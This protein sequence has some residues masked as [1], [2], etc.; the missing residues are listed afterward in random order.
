MCIG[1]LLVPNKTYDISSALSWSSLFLYMVGAYSPRFIASSY[2]GSLKQC[3]S[4]YC[5]N[6][7]N[8]NAK[9]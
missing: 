9:A 5:T 8:A 3:I 4:Y 1:L 7:H 2:S 6:Y